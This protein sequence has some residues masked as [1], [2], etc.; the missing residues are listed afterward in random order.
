MC[1]GT[2][3]IA[4]SPF[5]KAHPLSE[6][7]RQS[8]ITVVSNDARGLL[9]L[10]L[11]DG[12][13]NY[14]GSEFTGYSRPDSMTSK[15]TAI[16]STS[17][18]KFWV[19]YEDGMICFL[20][21]GR[22][23]KWDPE[24][25]LP[26][27]GITGFVEDGEGRLWIATYGEGLYAY[28][29]RRLYNFDTDDGLLSDDI[30]VMRSD[31]QGQIWVGTDNGISICSWDEGR[32]QIKNITRSKGLPDEIIHA[33]NQDELGNF[34]IG[35]HD[36]GFCYYDPRLDSI[37]TPLVTWE[38]GVI[39]DLMML[40]NK[41]LWVGTERNGIWRY[42]HSA[43]QLTP[44]PDYQEMVGRGASQFFRDS[45]A[46]LWFVGGSGSL[47]STNLQ[48]EFI[49]SWRERSQ[50]ILTDPSGRIW[51]GAT[52]GLFVLNP[53]TDPAGPPEKLL[54]DLDLNVISLF[55]DRF[56][57]LWIGTFG[58]G[59][60][61]FDSRSGQLIHLTE[62][63]GL[64][65]DNVL[66]IAGN[67]KEVWLATLGGV[68]S[69]SLRQNILEDVRPAFINYRKASGLGTDY[70]YQVFIDSKDRIWLATDGQ[71][72]TVME[73]ESM[74]HYRETDTGFSLKSIYSI[75]EDAEGDIWFSTAREGIFEY[76][77]QIFRNFN[78]ENGLRNLT[79]SGLLANHQGQ[80]MVIHPEGLD[81]LDSKSYQ[82]VYYGE[83]VGIFD[84]Q[85]NLN[86]GCIGSQGDVYIAAANEVV[87]FPTL[88]DRPHPFPRVDLKSVIVGAERINPSVDSIFGYRQN[89]FAF[90]F[91]GLWYTNPDRVRFRYRLRGYDP[92]WVETRDHSATYANL[93][94]GVYTF[95]VAGS[96][97]PEWTNASTVTYH[98][99][100]RRPFWQRWWFVLLSL[101]AACGII[102]WWQRQRE[103]R[104]QRLNQLE[105]QK[106]ASELAAL[107]AQINP[108]FL[109][110]SFNALIDAIEED[111]Q[112]AVEYVEQLS[113]FYRSLLQF[114]DQQLISL[115]EELRLV[116]NFDFLLRKRFGENF[117]LIFD[118]STETGFIPPLTLQ[119]LVENAVKH[120]IISKARPLEVEIKVEKEGKLSVINNLQPKVQRERSTQFGLEGL[121]KRY[122]LLDGGRIQIERSVGSF[123]VT[124]PLFDQ[125]MLRL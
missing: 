1:N 77:G 74:K 67:E 24:E 9:W 59:L 78:Q 120:N 83:D 57:V 68:S 93:L 104:L 69:Y 82:P 96:I 110:N 124:V 80:V 30:Y 43:G 87:V 89:Y 34:W 32:K 79:V 33:L 107:K 10:G 113:D 91:R 7:Y 26:V 38:N 54:P 95:E 100:V 99:R 55:F 116:R 106:I 19:G 46:N 84:W 109:F 123:K 18:G 118:V 22:L 73:A 48:F 90:R 119:I 121:Q 70:V 105:R 102:W 28:D 61:C 4:Q 115:E 20:A 6:P 66:S 41:Q 13:L 76:D 98:F 111:P 25:G 65:N 51:L 29:G 12:L 62:A 14:T 31:R 5:F 49:P 94:P 101:T 17:T 71:G 72:L 117:K 3:V 125:T 11:N 27:V 60:Y 58:G 21:E 112:K 86:A 52:D 122:E 92:N 64:A 42:D 35:T 8:R 103:Q 15:V 37:I 88:Y 97:G 2:S 114:R 40:D 39:N 85:V 56:G 81:V 50:C 16:Y 75:A 45:E 23:Q 36:H 63:G 53:G 47:W 44:I 108:H